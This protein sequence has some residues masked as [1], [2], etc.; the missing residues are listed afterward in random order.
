M[1][2]TTIS[3]L[4]V[5]AKDSRSCCCGSGESDVGAIAAEE[6]GIAVVSLFAFEAGADADYGDDDIGFARGGDGFFCEIWRK[7]EKAREGFA[8]VAEIFE[9]DG[10]GMA[11]L[12]VN[13]RGEGAFAALA[14]ENPI[15]N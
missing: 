11:G 2:R 7:P 15:V 6:T 12:K 13:Q 10:I 8:E 4:P 9:L 14:V 1:V 3:G 5:A